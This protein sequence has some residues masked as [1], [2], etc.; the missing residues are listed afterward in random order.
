MHKPVSAV[1]LQIIDRFKMKY[2]L[3][4]QP[5]VDRSYKFHEYSDQKSV[6][7]FVFGNKVNLIVILLSFNYRSSNK[8]TNQTLKKCESKG[9]KIV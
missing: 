4:A 5:G 7:N 9:E 1:I 2:T 8:N 3:L 6:C